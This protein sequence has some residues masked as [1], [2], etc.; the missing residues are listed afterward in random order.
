MN[1]WCKRMITALCGLVLIA[2]TGT[3]LAAE[4]QVLSGLVNQALTNNPDLQ[5]AEARWRMFERKVVPAGS[6]DDPQLALALVNFPVDSFKD[7]KTPMT[8]KD[9]R[10]TQKFPFPGKLGL[11]GEMAE[12]QA[13]WYRGAYEDAKLKL[14]LAVRESWYE[15][16]YIDKALGITEKNLAVL[17]DFLR[18]TETRYQVGTGLQQDVL[19]A[20]VERSKLMDRR[21]NLRQQRR[22]AA[23][24]IEKLVN[25]PLAEDLKALPEIEMAEVDENLE[26]FE[27]QAEIN[28]P[29]FNAYQALIDRF[30]AQ[31]DLA[32]LDYK[33]DFS[34]WAGYRF[35]EDNRVDDGVDFASAGISFNLPIYK[36]KRDE[37]VAE[38]DSGIRMA[39]HQYDDFRSQVRF[40][41]ED[42]YALMERNRDRVLLY[43]SGLMPQAE[44][45]FRAAMSSYQVGK[46]DFLTLLDALLTQFRYEIDYYRALADYQRAVARLQAE[47]GTPESYLKP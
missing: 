32:R 7:D 28:R 10:F 23:A 16:Y 42:A 31:R 37:A 33:P 25:R 5:A 4:P 24:R 29:L 12:Q 11:K 2:L 36:G 18:L 27:R 46:V 41:L 17:K 1:L 8:G 45:T 30:K 43:R 20:Q 15:L 44:Q 40:N 22:S 34:L 39:L 35:R 9:I 14:G 6:F 13:L 21:F 19:K 3:A 26:V 38:A 47:S